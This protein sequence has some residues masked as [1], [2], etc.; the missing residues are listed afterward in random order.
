MTP[1]CSRLRRVLC[2]G[3]LAMVLLAEPVLAQTASAPPLPRWDFTAHADL[4]SSRHDVP[5]PCCDH[6]SHVLAGG[7]GIGFYWTPNVKTEIDTATSVEG[8]HFVSVQVPVPGASFPPYRVG[9]RYYRDTTISAAQFY[10]FFRNQWF[11]PALGIGIDAQW[12]RSRGE[13]EPLRIYRAGTSET[14][15]PARTEAA[16]TTFRARP[17]VATSFKAYFSERVF[18]RTD[19]KIGP[20]RSRQVSWRTGFGVDF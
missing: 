2:A 14:L 16:K 15:E 9:R 6:W 4:Y 18:F 8:E 3:V 13:F 20:G 5:E 19:L 7:A 12:A 1:V 11:H 17:F 10:Q